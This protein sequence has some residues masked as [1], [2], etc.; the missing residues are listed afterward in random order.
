MCGLHSFVRTRQMS[1]RPSQI[2]AQIVEKIYYKSVLF[3]FAVNYLE[4][5]I[6]EKTNRVSGKTTLRIDNRHWNL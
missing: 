5:N 3:F 4:C 1:R 6:S 2:I